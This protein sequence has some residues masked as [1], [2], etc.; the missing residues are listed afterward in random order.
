MIVRRGK[1]TIV[2]RQLPAP[3]NTTKTSYERFSF[4]LPELLQ[5]L[6]SLCYVVSPLET[7]NATGLEPACEMKDFTCV[8]LVVLCGLVE[9]WKIF[10]HGRHKGG[11]LG[12]PYTDQQIAL[13]PAEWFEQKL[14]HFNPTDTTTWRQKYFTNSAFYKP[15]N[16]V[17]LM[18]GGEG[19]AN[20]TWMVKGTWI[21]YASQLGA[22]CF[23]L[24]H[25]FYG[26][27]HPTK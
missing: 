18:I 21:D 10:H 24:E 2:C 15:G 17:F 16:P 26:D 3:T 12:A 8:V 7:R 23:N 22:L 1:F 5:L 6:S 19:A 27:S 9:G 11:M 13:P 25:R 14:D 4:L 20:A